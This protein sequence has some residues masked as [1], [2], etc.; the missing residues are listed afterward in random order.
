MDVREEPLFISPYA[1]FKDDGII[2]MA[3]TLPVGHSSLATKAALDLMSQ[4]GLDKAEVVHSVSLTDGFTYLI[5]Y[6]RCPFKTDLRN[7]SDALEEEY[8]S[9][10]E[11]ERYVEEAV[12]RKIVI[13][14]ASTGT[15]T[16]SVGIDAMLNLKGFNGESGLEAYS[17]FEV[18]N[19]G[20]QVPNGELVKKAISVNAD[21]ILV[22]Q[23]V[24]QQKLHIHNLTQ[25]IDIVESQELRSRMLMICGGPRISDELVQELGYDAGF[26]KGCYPNHVASFVARAIARRVRDSEGSRLG[27]VEEDNLC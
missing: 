2:Q 1:D 20:S 21:A 15:D 9:Q 6:G 18:H 11:V 23:T 4:M 3:F 12:G 24:T 19:L 10:P 7:L 5:A 26:S 17:C 13:V 22:S 16:H 27:C 25:L 14:G 8:M